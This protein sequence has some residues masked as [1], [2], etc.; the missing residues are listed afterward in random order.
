MQGLSSRKIQ[1]CEA[2]LRDS[3]WC[4]ARAHPVDSDLAE[5]QDPAGA[6][7]HDPDP[8]AL[9]EAGHRLRLALLDLHVLGAGGPDAVVP[10]LDLEEESG[11]CTPVCFA[12]LVPAH[13]GLFKRKT[14]ETPRSFGSSVARGFLLGVPVI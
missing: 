10:Q 5:G 2:S 1:V 3:P 7:Q 11:L 9:A 6:R 13:P 12:I 8:A 14:H 4:E